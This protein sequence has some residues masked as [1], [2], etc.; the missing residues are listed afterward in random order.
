M[1]FG[2][3][4]LGKG[5]SAIPYH[6]EDPAIHDEFVQALGREGVAS[7]MN[8]EFYQRPPGEGEEVMGDVM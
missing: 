6:Q 4:D 8:P 3:I 1:D 5:G 2:A 7:R